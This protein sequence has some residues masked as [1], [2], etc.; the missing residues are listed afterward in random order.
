MGINFTAVRQLVIVLVVG[1]RVVPGDVY[2]QTEYPVTAAPQ[3]AW[4]GYA[5]PEAVPYQPTLGDSQPMIVGQPSGEWIGP[6]TG[7]NCPPGDPA[8]ACGQPCLP[9]PDTGCP[10]PMA[11]PVMPPPTVAF[12]N[13]IPG[14]PIKP[15][16]PPSSHDG[17]FQGV[18]FTGAYLP[19]FDDDSVGMSD[20][21]LD[22][23]FGLP[24]ATRETPLVVTPFYGVHFMDGPN[25]PDVPPRLHDAAVLFQNYRPLN[26]EW[27]LIFDLTI[28]EFADD[29]SFGSS[30]A[31]R[32]TGGGEA[33]YRTSDT[34]KWVLGAEY[35]DRI[36]TKVLPVAGFIY[37]PNDDAEYRV[38]F[39]APK[40]AW[41]LPWT[42]V[43]GRDERWFYVAGEFGG[44]A[45]AVERTT[46]AEDRLDITDWRV[47]LGVE[48]K[49]LGGLSRRVELGYVFARK[50]Q[51]G[52]DP[53]NEISLDDTLMARIG[54]A[55]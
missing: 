43:P 41:R 39:P 24:L 3:S 2:G 29:E 54:L 50:L 21:Q 33:V 31:L 15:W 35:V 30:D 11:M 23:S 49:I 9:Y 52:S 47:Y 16:F 42:D 28:G 34:W 6:P 10:P 55:Y 1:W 38:V 12:P 32:V 46:G 44:G 51:Y 22:V 27:M 7:C 5:M 45:W 17:F 36:N 25:S 20:L 26:D 4:G 14:G 18:K 40:L 53:D 37:T 19:R 13:A 8:A 48:H